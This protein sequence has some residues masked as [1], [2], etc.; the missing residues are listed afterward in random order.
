MRQK[1]KLEEVITETDEFCFIAADCINC[2]K[3]KI[4]QKDEY[5]KLRSVIS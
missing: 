4:K 3:A 2:D 5:F 1:E